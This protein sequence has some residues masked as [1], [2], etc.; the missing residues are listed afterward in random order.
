MNRS[1]HYF[2]LFLSFDA[3]LLIAV[4]KHFSKILKKKHTNTQEKNYYEFA[5]LG[6]KEGANGAT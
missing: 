5:Y 3:A 6:I 4:S 2:L 1:K